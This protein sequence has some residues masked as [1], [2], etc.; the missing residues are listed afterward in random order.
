MGSFATTGGIEIASFA[1][2]DYL[3]YNLPVGNLTAQGGSLGDRL[4]LT[5]QSIRFNDG[6]MFVLDGTTNANLTSLN[7][8]AFYVD[9][10]G[11][12][13]RYYDLYYDEARTLP[14]QVA[15]GT[16]DFTD[17]NANV[18]SVA[19]PMG[20]EIIVQDGSSP[21]RFGTRRITK[22]RAN[23]TMEFGATS[24]DDGTGAAASITTDGVFTTQGNIT[25]ANITGTYLYGDGTNISGIGGSVN[26]F[27]TIAVS[28]GNS[29][30]A[31]SST[32]TL[33]LVAAGAIT[34]TADA[35]TD[36]ITIGGTGG[37][38]GN[39]DVENFLSANVV[40]ANIETQG[41]IV[42]TEATANIVI[43][44]GHLKTDNFSP[45][46]AGARIVFPTTGVQFNDAK[47]GGVFYPDFGSATG[48]ILQ[49]DSSASANWVTDLDM[50]GRIKLQNLTTTQINALSS[51]EAGD[52]VF[53][54][55]EST[56]C[57]Y[58]GSA[59]R[60]VT[61]TAL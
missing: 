9:Q 48:A 8:Q 1:D 27:E 28:G 46:T 50:A 41:N 11:N 56:I 18:V 26:S 59:W 22:W 14:V 16:E 4:K 54:T 49:C 34:I 42:T 52:T 35:A 6:T 5:D 13:N 30:V 44:G 40:T 38:Y 36:T 23:G 10:G 39:V 12:P 7:G 55:T 45:F 61:S 21:D 33:N 31:D 53:N 24:T 19:Q 20:L 29:V 25:G 3:V 15:T 60:K 32:D 51:P 17:G 37:T 58:N 43:G 57:F 2:G 47:I